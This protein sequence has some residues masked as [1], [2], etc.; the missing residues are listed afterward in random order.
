MGKLKLQYSGHLMRRN[1][2]TGKDPDAGKD[3]RQNDR[4]WDRW[5]ASPAQWTW[6]WAS[7]RSWWWTGKP[8]MLQ[9]MGSQ[10][11]RHDWVTEVKLRLRGSSDYPTL[12]QGTPLPHRWN[13]R[14]KS[15]ALLPRVQDAGL[16]CDPWPAWRNAEA[17]TGEHSGKDSHWPLLR[18]GTG[19]FQSIL[20]P[21]P[22]QGSHSWFLFMQLKNA[23]HQRNISDSHP[24]QPNW[25][26]AAQGFDLRAIWCQSLMP[27]L[28]GDA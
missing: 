13:W 24:R 4:R 17:S 11:V 10:R 28:R 1:W 23:D 3:W 8:G 5:K 27:F 21:S 12:L 9:S 18:S 20:W 22:P 6:V 19:A 14:P 26:M 2:L 25:E 7:S 15:P 16:S